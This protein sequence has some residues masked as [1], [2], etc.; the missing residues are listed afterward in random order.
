M[1]SG[2]RMK[3]GS[4]LLLPSY[5]ISNDSNL[6]VVW[7]VGNQVPFITHRKN[8]CCKIV[9]EA[10]GLRVKNV[11]EFFRYQEKIIHFIFWSFFV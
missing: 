9:F 8:I 5:S 3:K 7:K 11:S 4:V 2:R 10:F 6:L 1:G